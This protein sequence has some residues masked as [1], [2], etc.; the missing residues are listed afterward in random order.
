VTKR[1]SPARSKC[2]LCRRD[3]FFLPPPFP[4][5]PLVLTREQAQGAKSRV[6]KSPGSFDSSFS[7][8]LPSP[9]FP[10]LMLMIEHIPIA[11]RVGLGRSNEG[12]A[13]ALFLPLL[14]DGCARRLRPSSGPQARALPYLRTT[15]IA[16]RACGVFFSLSSFS[17][18][19]G[20]AQAVTRE[21]S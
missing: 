1:V 2:C 20:R 19:S 4:P 5:P 8:F 3:S 11:D 16:L 17:L 6:M 14:G 21:T 9:P 13:S 12:I 15:L 10:V 18:F 7:F